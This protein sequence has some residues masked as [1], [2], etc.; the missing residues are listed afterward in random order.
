MHAQKHKEYG[1]KEKKK[2]GNMNY[3]G[4]RDLEKTRIVNACVVRKLE[5]TFERG[6]DE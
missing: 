4:H 3:H 1:N 2:G 5:E 6:K